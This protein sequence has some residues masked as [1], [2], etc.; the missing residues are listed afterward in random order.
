M[1]WRVGSTF[2]CSYQSEQ[3]EE[4]ENF[5]PPKFLIITPGAVFFDVVNS[6]IITNSFRKSSTPLKYARIF[7]RQTAMQIEP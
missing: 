3:E 5:W 2:T 7:G 1:C 4:E 6:I